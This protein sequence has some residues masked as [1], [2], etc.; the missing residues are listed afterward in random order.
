MYPLRIPAL[1]NN[2]DKSPDP[3][4]TSLP[5]TFTPYFNFLFLNSPSNWW[6]IWLCSRKARKY[7][8]KFTG[9]RSESK[10]SR[11]PYRGHGIFPNPKA[12][13][14]GAKY[15]AYIGGG[16]ESLF[17]NGKLGI[18]LSSKASLKRKSSEFFQVPKPLRGGELGIFLIPRAY[19]R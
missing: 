8:K 12:S 14:E 10:S 18:C 7:S 6:P 5:P 11:R 15:R 3:L 9:S 4:T 1:C 2:S 13:I 17:R 19:I 16:S